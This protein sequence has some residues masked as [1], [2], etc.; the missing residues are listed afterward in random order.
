VRQTLDTI[1]QLP[2][3]DKLFLE[4]ELHKRNVQLR[5]EELLEDAVVGK[6]EYHKGQTKTFTNA[7]ELLSDLLKT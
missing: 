4:E 1:E 2:T 6:Q 3:R 7:D 5:R